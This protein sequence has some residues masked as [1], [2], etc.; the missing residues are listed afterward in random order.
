[1]VATIVICVFILCP[2]GFYFIRKKDDHDGNMNATVTSVNGD[3]G[4][5]T[6]EVKKSSKGSKSSTSV[7]YNCN[8]TYEFEIG[9]TKYEGRGS[10]NSSQQYYV[11]DKINIDYVTHNPDK[12]RIHQVPAK[13]IGYVILAV[14]TLL[15]LGSI[16]WYYFTKNVRGAGTLGVG[17]TVLDA[18]TD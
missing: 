17:M 13:T 3:Q 11:G 2:I 18:V 8:V 7:T 9:S 1:M 4:K 6:Q 15:M 10:T 16:A 12:N 14:A 5:C